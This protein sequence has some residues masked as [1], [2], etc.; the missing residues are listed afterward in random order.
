MC[1]SDEIQTG[2]G[3]VGEKFWGFE[4]HDVVPDIVTIG[5]SFG[6]GHPVAAVICKKKIADK[7]NNGME[8]FSSFGGN[9]VSCATANEVSK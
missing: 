4:L 9:P 7:F 3:R 2:L 5:K 8:F 1:I 6:N